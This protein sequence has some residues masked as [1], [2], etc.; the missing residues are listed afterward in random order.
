VIEAARE[1][2]LQ[3]IPGALTPSEVLACVQEGNDVV[4]LFPAHAV[5]PPYLRDLRS[6]MPGLRAIATGGIAPDDGSI[7]SWLEAGA[8]AVGLGSS[9]GTVAN[10][11]AETV[12]DRADRALAEAQAARAS[13]DR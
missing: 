7:A 5:G 1:H 8:M 12:G 6:V 9:L 10:V 11:G 4:K 13:A 2:G 3:I